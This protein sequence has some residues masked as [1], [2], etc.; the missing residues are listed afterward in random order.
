MISCSFSALVAVLDFRGVEAP[1]ERTEKVTPE[2][3]ERKKRVRHLALQIPARDPERCAFKRDSALLWEDFDGG[4]VAFHVEDFGAAVAAEQVAAVV[5]D[6]APVL[7]GVVL[8][9]ALA[10]ARPG[11]WLTRVTASVCERSGARVAVVQFGA[12]RLGLW[13]RF[14]LLAQN[15]ESI[16]G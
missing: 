2:W 5:A 15:L 4:H 6:G 14:N 1:A 7:V 11:R 10:V 12:G 3:S 9:A 16:L 8:A 13:L